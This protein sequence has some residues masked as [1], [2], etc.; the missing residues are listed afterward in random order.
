MYSSTISL[1]LNNDDKEIKLIN[2]KAY[3]MSKI[4]KITKKNESE[5]STE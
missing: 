3:V 1:E 5:F 4:S 2:L